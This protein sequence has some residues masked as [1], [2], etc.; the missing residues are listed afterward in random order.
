M[1]IITSSAKDFSYAVNIYIS[2]MTLSN[3]VTSGYKKQYHNSPLIRASDP[4][5]CTENLALWESAGDFL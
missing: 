4:Q 2:A 3:A 1:R 5:A